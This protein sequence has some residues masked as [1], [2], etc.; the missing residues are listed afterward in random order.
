VGGLTPSPPRRETTI[1]AHSGRRLRG[2]RA[3]RFNVGPRAPIRRDSPPT[4][5]AACVQARRPKPEARNLGLRFRAAAIAWLARL[6][7]PLRSLLAAVVERSDGLIVVTELDGRIAWVN[8]GFVRLSGF[9]SAQAL[10]R[11]PLELLATF[12]S[13]GAGLIALLLEGA[14]PAAQRR[15]VHQLKGSA[16]NVR[17]TRLARAAASV[18]RC[19][20]TLTAELLSEARRA[21]EATQSAAQA[22]LADAA[23]DAGG[24]QRS[25]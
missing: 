7:R 16:T 25:A 4:V 20:G 8:E 13:S 1:G 15:A 19:S 6:L 24:Q 18:E 21:W 9:T 22:A 2:P 11:T 14:D 10:G 23:A 12:L 5:R 17:A 3:G